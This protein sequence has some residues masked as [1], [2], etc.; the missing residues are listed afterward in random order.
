MPLGQGAR[1]LVLLLAGS[2][3]CRPLSQSHQQAGV[4]GPGQHTP[5]LGW[6]LDLGWSGQSLEAWLPAW[7]S[8]PQLLMLDIQ[9]T[10]LFLQLDF[11]DLTL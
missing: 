1:D 10:L 7:C 5:P 4:L 6:R 11:N 3:C 8:H 9:P 2:D